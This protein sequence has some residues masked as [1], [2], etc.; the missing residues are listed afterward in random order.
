MSRSIT[1]RREFAIRG[2]GLPAIRGRTAVALSAALVALPTMASAANITWSGQVD[3]TW[4]NDG[5]WIGGTQPNPVGTDTVTFSN[6]GNGNTV[7]D[8]GTIT[9]TSNEQTITFDTDQ[10]ASYTIGAGGAGAQ[11]LVI[12]RQS[13]SGNTAR[14]GSITVTSA[15]VND[16]VFD[17]NVKFGNSGGSWTMNLT[18]NSPT[19]DLIFNGDFTFAGTGK[20]LRFQGVGDVYVNGTIGSTNSPTVTQNSTGTTHL[21]NTANSFNSVVRVY[22]G[23]LEFNS[24][25]NYGTPSSLG[26]ASSTSGETKLDLAGGVLRFVGAAGGT[27]D[28]LFTLGPGKDG[29]SSVIEASGEVPLQFTSTGDVAFATHPISNTATA[30]SGATTITMSDTSRLVVGMA[31]SGSRIAA[32]TTITEINGNVITISNPTSGGNLNSGSNITFSGGPRS[33]TLGGTGESENI[34]SPVLSDIGSVNGSDPAIG[35]TSLV[36]AGST[37][38]TLTSA[39]TYTG[40][41]TITGGVLRLDSSGSISDSGEVVINAGGVLDVQAHSVF[42]L[43]STQPFTFGLDADGNGLA[44]LLRAA[45]LDIT[46]GIITFDLS[47]SL[48]DPAYVIAEYGALTGSEFA[49]V[50]N[51]PDGYSIDYQ[52]NGGTQIALVVP[53]PAALGWLGIL[54]PMALRRRRLRDTSNIALPGMRRDR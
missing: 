50:I 42:S 12:G 31:V 41:T 19:A 52:Y 40:A 6:A 8:L 45:E 30:P 14:G 33:L 46:N 27:T 3:G 36:K 2:I 15:V 35:I 20:G 17:A 51:L 23:V 4:A 32:G 7:I 16:Q 38:W 1:S 25:A 26:A 13:P 39:H 18:N 9:Y 22:Q 37:T 24:I 54:L 5:N 10:A 44:G 49:D 34:F 53:E 29:A 28:R 47:T 21:T 48:D 11:T 43:Q